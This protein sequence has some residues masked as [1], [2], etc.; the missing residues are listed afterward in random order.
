[1]SLEDTIAQKLRA[2]LRPQHLDVVNESGMHSVPKGS[3]TH[4]KVVVVSD[5]FVGKNR[6]QRHQMIYAALAEEMKPGGIHALA[7]TTRTPEEWSASSESNASPLC[8][9]GSK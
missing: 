1:V 9:G 6:V 4:F 8:R 2:V 5:A 7:M 3:E